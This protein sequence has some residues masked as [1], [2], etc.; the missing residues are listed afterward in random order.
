[1]ITVVEL[2]EFIRRAKKLLDESERGRLISHLA[3]NPTSGVVME[4]TGGIRE[5][6]VGKEK[7]RARAVGYG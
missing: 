6:C 1:M 2:P 5:N 3:A 7:A 4:G